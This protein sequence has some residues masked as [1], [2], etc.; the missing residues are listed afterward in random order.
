MVVVQCEFEGCDKTFDNSNLETYLGLLKI[1]VAAVH[2]QNQAASKAEKA[3]RPELASDVSDEDWS[4][5]QSRWTQYKKATGLQGEDVI[6]Q[7]LECCSEPLRRDHYRTFS[8]ATETV[9][10]DSILTQLKQIA[11]CKRN[12]SVNRVKLGTLKQDKGE[13]IRKFAGRVR[14]QKN[15]WYSSVSL[16]KEAN[17]IKTVRTKKLPARDCKQKKGK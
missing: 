15:I 1:H 10:E 14:S 12:K 7:L 11:V 17:N 3:K 4:Y 8:G 5:F 16:K 9:T 6:T 13:P 2:Q